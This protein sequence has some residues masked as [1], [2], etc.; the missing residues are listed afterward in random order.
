MINWKKLN[1][2][3][4]ISV[5]KWSKCMNRQLKIEIEMAFWCIKNLFR[6]LSTS[7]MQIKITLI[8]YLTP[9]R[10]LSIGQK[11]DKNG[12]TIITPMSDSWG[13]ILEYPIFETV[14]HFLTFWNTTAIWLSNIISWW[15]APVR[16]IIVLKRYLIQKHI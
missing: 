3:E 6:L 14:W 10:I 12:K 16:N 4:T 15:Y 8:K 1:I 2:R 11:K 9:V 7:E 5:K 13:S